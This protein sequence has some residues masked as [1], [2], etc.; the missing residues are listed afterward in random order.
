[1]DTWQL[2]N[3]DS[4]DTAGFLGTGSSEASFPGAGM[5]LADV[6]SV[7]PHRM[8]VPA[9]AFSSQPDADPQA[10][11]V[12]LV[13]QPAPLP[14]FPRS[15]AASPGPGRHDMPPLPLPLPQPLRGVAAAQHGGP[16]F[17]SDAGTR[18]RV[19]RKPLRTTPRITTATLIRAGRQV[20][21]S[22]QWPLDR[23][24]KE[25]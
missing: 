16:G 21:L 6:P 13:Q 12:Q 9:S 15:T 25:V 10:G 18:T 5:P 17:R 3:L 1:M 4:L 2:D 8:S 22:V 24:E 11:L 14:P 19:A 23:L 7:T 20:L